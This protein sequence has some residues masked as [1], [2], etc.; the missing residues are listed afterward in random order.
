MVD[1]EPIVIRI[2]RCMSCGVVVFEDRG[3]EIDFPLIAIAIGN[4]LNHPRSAEAAA[5]VHEFQTEI[6]STGET[7]PGVDLGTDHLAQ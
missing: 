7:I 3:R 5:F 6:T 4:H 1:R 2:I